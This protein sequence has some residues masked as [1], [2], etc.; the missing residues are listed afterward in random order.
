MKKQV[1]RCAVTIKHTS[2]SVQEAIALFRSGDKPL[3]NYVRCGHE[4]HKEPKA[5]Y[6]DDHLHLYLQLTGQKRLGQIYNLVMETWQGRFYGRPDVRQLKTATDAAKWNNYCKKDGDYQDEGELKEAGPPRSSGSYEDEAYASFLDVARQEGQ[7]A[8]MAYAA[9]H[10]VK[11]YCTRYSNLLES[12]KSVCPPSQKYSAPSMNAQFVKPRLWQKHFLPRV[13]ESEPVRR[14][15]H[16]VY[17]SPGKGKTW[18]KDYLTANHPCGVFDASDRCAIGDLAYQYNEEGIIQWDFPLNFDW[19]NMETAATSVIEKFSDFGSKIRSLKYKGH[20]PT[21]LCHVVVFANRPCPDRLKHRDVIEFSI[22]E[23]EAQHPP[24]IF[25]PPV[26]EN[27]EP[28]LQLDCSNL[29][30]PSKRKPTPLHKLKKIRLL[31]EE[32]EDHILDFKHVPLSPELREDLHVVELCREHATVYE[33]CQFCN[34]HRLQ[35]APPA[36]PPEACAPQAK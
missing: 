5:G 13:M 19:E 29:K 28:P 8:A 27:P 18:I 34:D 36:G 9:Q 32:L 24:E 1:S 11:E 31:P 14:R 12:A 6:P 10:L 33:A 26:V 3:C 30:P 35:A 25:D 17:G 15:I 23:F 16:W 7:E 20:N 4:Y 22:D 21:V 2:V